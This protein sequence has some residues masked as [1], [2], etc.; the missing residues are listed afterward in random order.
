[1]AGL[2]QNGFVTKTLPEI[3]E[4][5]NEA[6]RAM[7]GASINLGDKSILGQLVGIISERLA[8]LWELGEAI[9]SSQDP[10]KAT[11]A[12][13]EALCLLTGT[14]RPSATFS[15]VMLTLCGDDGTLVETGKQIQTA[16]TGVGFVTTEDVTLSI[17]PVWATFTAYSS[18]AR[19][20]HNGLVFECV[21]AGVSGAAGPSYT[22]G[23]NPEDIV[24]G[25]VHWAYLGQGEAVGEV[26]ARAEQLGAVVARA[27][28]LTVIVNGVSGWTTVTNRLDA[29]P[30]REVAT[31]GEL[32]LLREQQLAQG[33]SATINALRAELLSLPE[34]QTVTVFVNNTDV[35]DPDGIP[36][37]AIEVM[38]RGPEIPDAAFDQRIFDTLLAGVAAG[39]RTHGNVSGTSI[40]DEG[41]AHVMKFTRPTAIPIYVDIS[42]VVDPAVFPLDGADQVKQAIVDWGDQQATGKDAVAAAIMAQAFRVPGVL[43]VTACLIDTTPA[44]SSSATIAINLRQ[45]ATYDTARINVTT[46]PGV[47]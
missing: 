40:D 46:T 21:S 30:G 39:I 12:A 32:R 29:S 2:T 47:P 9:N 42:L 31:D 37:H 18:G 36:P 43:D 14:F 20:R 27:R 44:P 38:V 13:L 28:D 8:V 7:F 41:T 22:S 26:L 16:S 1:M 33:G 4:D 3:R 11:G 10:D 23:D 6:L 24:D 25:T 45:L 34:V 19:V 15:S 35:T 5:I 17:V